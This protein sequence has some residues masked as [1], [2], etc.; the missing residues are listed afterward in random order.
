MIVATGIAIWLSAWKNDL[1]LLA[2]RTILGLIN[3]LN[4][5]YRQA[6]RLA[7]T[8]S[9]RLT[10]AYKDSIISVY[11]DIVIGCC[12]SSGLYT[13]GFALTSIQ[14]QVAQLLSH[15]E[16]LDKYYICQYLSV[17]IRTHPYP[18]V[19]VHLRPYPSV[20]PP[21]PFPQILNGTHL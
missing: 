19:S 4:S 12:C 8:Q 20:C 1:T 7:G 6:G 10:N 15:V 3:C 9:L 11:R 2:V 16:H 17:F 18:S 13:L 5:T 21:F 14:T